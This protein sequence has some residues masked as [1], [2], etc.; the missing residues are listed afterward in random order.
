[1]MLDQLQATVRAKHRVDVLKRVSPEITSV[2]QRCC[3]S[4]LGALLD[5][6]LAFAGW[7]E[8]WEPQ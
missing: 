1:M 4:L 6:W 7:C 8:G 5:L 3:S 2:A